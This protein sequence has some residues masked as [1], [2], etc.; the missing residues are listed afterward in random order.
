MHTKHEL[1]L[2]IQL[3]HRY[4]ENIIIKLAQHYPSFQNYG[5]YLY[6]N[7]DAQGRPLREAGR[8]LLNTGRLLGKIPLSISV[9]YTPTNSGRRNV[10]TNA[11]KDHEHQG[12]QEQMMCLEL[13]VAAAFHRTQNQNEGEDNARVKTREALA[14][15]YWQASNNPAIDALWGENERPGLHDETRRLLHYDLYSLYEQHLQG[16]KDPLNR[17]FWALRVDTQT[18]KTVLK[19]AH[20]QPP[21]QPRP[22]TA[23][24]RRPRHYKLR[25]RPGPLPRAAAGLSRGAL[26]EHVYQSYPY[27]E[28]IGY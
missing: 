20:A 2:L 15:L 6:H 27:S 18:M 13:L 21:R 3:A 8:M 12:R 24:Q 9:E 23:A 10:H 1:P 14:F 5:E 22:I 19:H 26:L 25:G 11:L 4:L 16:N 17:F 7:S 28:Q